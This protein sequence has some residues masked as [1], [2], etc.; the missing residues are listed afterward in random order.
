MHK[1]LARLALGGTTLM[2]VLVL[3]LFPLASVFAD[4][5]PPPTEAPAESSEEA[6]PSQEE[7]PAVGEESPS[8]PED[9]AA[10]PEPAAI[11][12]AAANEADAAEPTADEPQAK[13]A[14][15]PSLLEVFIELLVS[16]WVGPSDQSVEDLTD[17]ED[18]NGNDLHGDVDCISAICEKVTGDELPDPDENGETIV[19]F[20]TIDGD[21]VV[22]H[23]GG[24]TEEIVIDLNSGDSCDQSPEGD[25]FCAGRDENGDI[26][27]WSNPC[28]ETVGRNETCKPAPALSYVLAV[29]TTEP[30]CEE[31]CET[32]TETEETP[33]ETEETPTETSTV[34]VT[35]TVT[36]TPCSPDYNDDEEGC[37]SPPTQTPPPPTIGEQVKNLLGICPV[38]ELILHIEG[39]DLYRDF[40]AGDYVLANQYDLTLY[41]D[42]PV[43]KP[44]GFACVI[45]AE[46][47]REGQKDLALFSTGGFVRWLTE[48]PEDETDPT[49]LLN[50]HIVYSKGGML[51]EIDQLGNLIAELGPGT[52]PVA[53][54][55]SGVLAYMAA[56]GS[57]ISNGEDTGIDGYPINWV[58]DD[59]SLLYFSEGK[60]MQLFPNGTTEEV[61]GLDAAPDPHKSLFNGLISLDEVLKIWGFN[62]AGFTVDG[63]QQDWWL[64]N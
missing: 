48:T 32:P 39:D 56:D 40:L 5:P 19:P 35:V 11:E 52:V 23:A 10:T 26:V 62:P 41:F 61:G 59:V 7:V 1:K 24:G 14:S 63:R 12:T 9:P 20:D 44:D 58:T 3:A 33:T 4:D 29:D 53:S 25:P 8:A 13:L 36:T 47:T 17:L 60:L 16:T 15:E 54:N 55:Y 31:D 45:V 6:P 34:T 27:I 46:A 43:T 2:M 50:G 64:A 30:P 18:S 37:G 42:F 38:E 57:L 21:V 28:A 49:W 51:Y 22:I